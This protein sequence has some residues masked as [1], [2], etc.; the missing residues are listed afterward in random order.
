MRPNSIF[1]KC[2]ALYALTV[3]HAVAD[4]QCPTKRWD[5]SNDG[6][7]YIAQV[8]NKAIYGNF[9]NSSASQYVNDGRLYMFGDIRNDGLIGDGFGLEF[10]RSCDNTITHINGTG[11]TEFNRLNINNSIGV[12]LEQLMSIKTVL[13]FAA[14]II[15]SDRTDFG[16][17]TI[18]Q[19]GA[20][21]SGA[22]DKKHIDGIVK[23]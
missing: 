1:I 17:M 15:H 4:A 5:T 11:T 20:S 10:I 3:L 9:T 7:A 23:K 22:N 2:M 13:Q 18:F 12:Q 16:H 8:G 6:S 21:Y 14:G 19:D